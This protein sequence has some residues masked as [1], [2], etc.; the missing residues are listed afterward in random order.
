MGAAIGVNGDVRARAE[1]L[2]VAGVDIL[3]VDTAHGHQEKMIE[4]LGRSAARYVAPV[5][6]WSRATS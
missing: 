6:R 2:L 3:V 4:A 1:A 5:C